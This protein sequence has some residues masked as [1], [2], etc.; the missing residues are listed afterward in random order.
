MLNRYRVRIT[1]R[2]SNDIIAICAHIEGSSPQNAAGVAQELIDA[3]DSLDL[4]PHRY[5][6]HEHRR[7][8]S[9]TVRSMPVP[10][11]IVYYRVRDADLV[12]E[13]IS[14]RHGARRQP[15]RFR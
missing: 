13:I 7:D 9:K 8:P 10:P 6:V 5:K 11:F 1:P 14:V 12:V 4:F 15:R 2:A 3:I